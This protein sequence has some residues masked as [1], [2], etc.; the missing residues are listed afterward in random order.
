[1]ANRETKTIRLNNEYVLYFKNHPEIS[2]SETINQAL[3]KHIVAGNPLTTPIKE[4]ISDAEKWYA[5]WKKNR[6][7]KKKL[8]AGGVINEEERSKEEAN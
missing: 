8:E 7:A 6:E 3:A 2:I 1:M 4:K 5:D